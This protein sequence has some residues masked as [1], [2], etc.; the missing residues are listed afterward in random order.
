MIIYLLFLKALEE[1]KL[2]K[3]K[4]PEKGSLK[5]SSL[6]EYTNLINMGWL[7]YGKLLSIETF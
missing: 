6:L 2:Q 4:L 1:I 3:I 5:I 7:Y